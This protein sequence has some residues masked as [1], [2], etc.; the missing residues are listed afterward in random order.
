MRQSDHSASVLAVILIVHT[1]SGDRFGGFRC[2]CTG[3]HHARFAEVAGLLSALIWA[4]QLCHVNG[5]W[6]QSSIHFHFDCMSAGMLAQGQWKSQAPLDHNAFR[7]IVHWLEHRYRYITVP[8]WHHVPAHQGHPWNEAADAA[9][10]AAVSHWTDASD[11]TAL[12][13]LIST[14]SGSLP[15]L[16][17]LEAAQQSTSSFPPPSMMDS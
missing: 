4:A 7:S 8:E 11:F 3:S 17:M 5:L 13:D 14:A 2:L 15:W 6:F 16:W 10:W 1:Q 9:A 12:H